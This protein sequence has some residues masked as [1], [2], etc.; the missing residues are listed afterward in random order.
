MAVRKSRLWLIVALLAVGALAWATRPTPT[1]QADGPTKS[2]A[3]APAVIQPRPEWANSPSVWNLTEN[4]DTVVPA[5]WTANNQSQPVGSIGWFQGNDG[6]FPAHQRAPTAY[7][8][9]NFN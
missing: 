1:V 9:V 6:V 2:P 7:A 8:G 4:F 5:G 3:G